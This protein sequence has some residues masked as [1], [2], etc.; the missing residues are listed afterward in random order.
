MKRSHALVDCM[1]GWLLFDVGETKRAVP[2]TFTAHFVCS[3]FSWQARVAVQEKKVA[4]QFFC[5]F[6][7]GR[8]VGIRKPKENHVHARNLQENC[9]AGKAK[10]QCRKKKLQCS[11]LA[12]FCC[13]P[14]QNGSPREKKVAAESLPHTSRK[15]FATPV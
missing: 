2:E 4:A 6:C 10:L 11:F 13:W 9:N 8:S 15:Q 3:F 7:F 14:G 1:F 12:V 5:S